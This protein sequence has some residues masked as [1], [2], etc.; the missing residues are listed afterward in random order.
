MTDPKFTVI[1]LTVE[2]DKF[3]LIV[4][5]DPAL[6]YKLGKRTDLSSVLVSDEIYSD[7]NK[8]SRASSEKLMKHFKSIDA[9]EVA[10][11]IMTRGEL[12]LT[13]DQRRK[14]VEEK[15]KQIVQFINRSF[16]DPKTHLP[17]PIVRIEAA[18]DEARL[19]VDPF[20]RA[21]DQAK[22]VIEGL[23][24]ILPLK[25]ET[26]RLIVTVPPQFSAQ[27]YSI[28]KS[29]GDFKGE[30]WLSDGSLRATV[31]LNAGLKAQFLDRLGSVSKGSAIVKEG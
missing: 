22:T 1:R 30:E 19:S 14:M 13:T 15:R 29:A 20:K 2:G 12:N 8:G 21:E 24:K 25:S 18:M 4:K 9:T 26:V 11:Q 5:P 16:V 23:R 31:E 10:K 27:S 3:E 6:E 28:L 17:H 7:A